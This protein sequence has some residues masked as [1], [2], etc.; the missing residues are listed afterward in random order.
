M[1]PTPRH[2]EAAPLQ[3][4]GVEDCKPIGSPCASEPHNDNCDL[5]LRRQSAQTNRTA[6]DERKTEEEVE[7]PDYDRVKTYQSFG[8]RAQLLLSGSNRR[9][10][11]SERSHTKNVR[12]QHNRRI[13][14]PQKLSVV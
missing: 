7:A 3:A 14:T 10:V 1:K 8:A 4:Y 9:T 11:C 12:S 13:K 6:G 2:T 5:N